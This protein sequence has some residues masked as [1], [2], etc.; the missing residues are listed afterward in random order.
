VKLEEAIKITRDAIDIDLPEEV[1]ELMQKT[2]GPPCPDVQES[3]ECIRMILSA[4]EE[5]RRERDRAMEFVRGLGT[6]ED[7]AE[8]LDEPVYWASEYRHAYQMLSNVEEI[9][10]RADKMQEERDEYSADLFAC[11]RERDAAHNRAERLNARIA[12]LEGDCLVYR[13]ALG[14]PVPG[15]TANTV[16]NGERPICGMCDAREKRIAE[17]EEKVRQIR[18]GEAW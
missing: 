5:A 13:G 15:E 2:L 6:D 14:Y 18:C 1:F 7:S 9:Q 11:Q 8:L 12:E 4:L 3:R 10:A 16:S 17:L